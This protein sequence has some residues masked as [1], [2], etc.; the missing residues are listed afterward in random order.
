MSRLLLA[1]VL[2]SGCTVASTVALPA[3]PADRPGALA[4]QVELIFTREGHHVRGLPAWRDTIQEELLALGP[5]AA[6]AAALSSTTVLELRVDRELSTGVVSTV[7]HL[8]TGFLWPHAE[9]L[10]L[11]VHGALRVEG[12]V[13]ASASADAELS[14][15][16]SSALLLWPGAWRSAADGKQELPEVLEALRTCFRR[17]AADLAEARGAPP[18]ETPAPAPAASACPSCARTAQPD[19]VACPWC[20]A[21][22]GR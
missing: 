2:L 19:W 16:T 10:K 13:V 15:H 17:V 6:D 1:A 22:L 5:V 7:L 11:A 18:P 20:G 3:A 21:P 9:D 12:E 8:F 14:L 4:P